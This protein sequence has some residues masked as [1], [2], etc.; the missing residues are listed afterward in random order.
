[1]PQRNKN[2]QKAEQ[3]AARQRENKRRH[4]EKIKGRRVTVYASSVERLEAARKVVAEKG[5]TLP[6][7]LDQF[8]DM[9]AAGKVILR[10]KA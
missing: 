5:L 7:F 2:S 8:I 6:E 3:N 10:R 9:I 4:W 1:M